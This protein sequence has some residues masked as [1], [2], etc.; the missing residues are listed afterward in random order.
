M[1][2][3]L[4]LCLSDIVCIPKLPVWL[5]MFLQSKPCMSVTSL[6][7]SNPKRFLPCMMHKPWRRLLLPLLNTF[8]K[9]ILHN[10]SFVQRLKTFQKHIKYHLVDFSGSDNNFRALSCMFSNSNTNAKCYQQRNS[11]ERFCW[12]LMNSIHSTI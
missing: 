7:L 6:P 3:L 11:R 8:P 12:N 10:M 2:E 1:R 9:D 5:C 4:K